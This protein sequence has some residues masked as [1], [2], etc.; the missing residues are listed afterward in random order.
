[1][2]FWLWVEER[3]LKNGKHKKSQE[4]ENGVYPVPDTLHVLTHPPHNNLWGRCYYYPHFTAE[5]MKAL[6]DYASC[7]RS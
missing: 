3:L 5:E 6:R 1:M 4:T 7:P 2:S